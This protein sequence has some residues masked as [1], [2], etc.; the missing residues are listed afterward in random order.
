MVKAMKVDPIATA[1]TKA[2]YDCNAPLYDLIEG[3]MELLALGI[4]KLIVAR[5]H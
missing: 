5:K 4:V 1:Q 2:R 3:P